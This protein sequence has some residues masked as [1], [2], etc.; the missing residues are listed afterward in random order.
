MENSRSTFVPIVV[1]G[2]IFLIVFLI[3]CGKV[4]VQVLVFYIYN[5]VFGSLNTCEM[6][7]IVHLISA[8]SVVIVFDDRSDVSEKTMKVT[9][10]SLP[11]ENGVQVKISVIQLRSRQAKLFL[12]KIIVLVF[13]GECCSTRSCAQ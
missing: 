5:R 8:K 12:A 10:P 3:L 9:I 4:S 1:N 7:A 11:K 2:V 13:T 6:F